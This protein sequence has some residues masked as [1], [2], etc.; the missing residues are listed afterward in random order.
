MGANPQIGQI[1][2][3]RTDYRLT[4]DDPDG[5]GWARMADYLPRN[6]TNFGLAKISGN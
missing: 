1:S 4:T 2:A 3:V 6:G 5:H